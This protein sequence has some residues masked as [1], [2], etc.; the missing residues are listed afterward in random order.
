MNA[1]VIFDTCI[2]NN[3]NNN[4]KNNNYNNNNNN[5]NSNND[6]NNLKFNNNN[7]KLYISDFCSL[8]KQSFIYFIEKSISQTLVY[9]LYAYLHVI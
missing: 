1:K 8:K 2:M 4:N 5:S 6:N 9:I 3:N 7:L